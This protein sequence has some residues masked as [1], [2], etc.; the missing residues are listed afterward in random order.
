MTEK[1]TE[2]VLETKSDE[3]A[4]DP[5]IDNLEDA[6]K[7]LK[8]VRGEAARRRVQ[9][10]E[11]EEKAAKWEE[12]VRNQKTDLEKLT[13]DNSSLKDENTSLKRENLRNKVALE[14]GLD[15]DLIEFLTGE[16]EDEMKAKAAILIEKSGKATG[17]PQVDL[18]AGQRGNPV[19]KG[20][21]Q[22]F[23]DVLLDLWNKAS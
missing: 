1:E 13:E 2:E 7:E 3:T 17:K 14:T 15:K 20:S 18:F 8:K 6:L 4:D 11:T 10:K 21:P 9:N 22:T 5:G 19:G 23:N 16:T 12:H